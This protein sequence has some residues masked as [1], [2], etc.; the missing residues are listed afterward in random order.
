MH[1]AIV[2]TG[3]VAQALGRGWADAGH[4]V[5][6]LSRDSDS[7]G[8][9]NILSQMPPTVSIRGLHGGTQHASIIVLA[10]P[11][12]AVA[13]LLPLL[14]DLTDKVIIDCTNPIAP[15][16]R[17]LVDSATSGAQQIAALA[18]EARVVKGF[19]TIGYE[20]MLD[21]MYR[22]H[23][24]TMLYCGDDLVAKEAMRQLAAD[25]NFEPADAG[26]LSAARHLEAF[27]L[28]WIYLTTQPNFGRQIAF[29]LE[30]R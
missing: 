13:E 23:A 20:G 30:Q 12:S 25:L 21:A 7:V 15:G 4:M 27:A 29:R 24:A 9:T 22:G 6:L 5:T 19:N 10:V 26:A 8:A 28:L 11:Y 2:G 14:G 18:P 3:R 17:S 16:L 1:I